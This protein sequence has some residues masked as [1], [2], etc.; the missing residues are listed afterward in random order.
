MNQGRVIFRQIMDFLPMHEF[1]TCVDRYR[2]HHKVQTF[3][4]FDQFLCMAFAQLTFRDSLRDIETCLRSFQSKLYHAGFRGSISRSTLAY[5]NETRS[6]Q[7]YADFAQILIQRART[8]YATDSF[9]VDL[10]EAAY[11]FDST[12]IDLCLSLFPWARFRKHK[13]AVKLHT[14]ID[15][16]GSIPCFIHITDGQVAD[17]NTLDCL[18]LEPGAFYMIDRG[19]IDFA[20]LYVFVQALAYFV[21]RAKSNLDYIRTASRPIDK[22]TGLRSDQTIRL[23]GLKTSKEYPDQLRRISYHDAETDKRLVF[24]TNNFTLPALT[25]PQLYKC[26]WRVELFFKWIKQYL[27]IKAFYGTSENAVRT[28]IWIAVSVYVLVAILKKELDIDRSLGEIL[29]ILSISLFE[30]E[31]MSQVLSAFSLQNQNADASQQL[32]LNV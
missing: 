13:A 17:V 29:Q 11:A 23:S 7:I 21:T 28:Q 27:R 22:S 10:K 20:R 26:R 25:I 19:Y 9:G 24:L 15:L 12:T 3:S 4:C 2:G 6:W 5:A 32:I 31:P 1:R 8:L 16:R 14:L 30:K 18:L